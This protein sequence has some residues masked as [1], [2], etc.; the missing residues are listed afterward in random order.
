M[1][2]GC[3][4]S[5]ALHRRRSPGV[6]VMEMVTQ[7]ETEIVQGRIGNGRGGFIYR[8]F[9]SEA[10]SINVVYYGRP[11]DCSAPYS[12][13]SLLWSLC[14]VSLKASLDPETR[15]C[16]FVGTLHEVTVGKQCTYHVRTIERQ[17][18]LSKTTGNPLKNWL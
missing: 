12:V 7:M 9:P 3:V 4:G 10:Y 8:F 17:E 16:A 2:G 13:L 15:A 18:L 6:K 14:I 1:N 11:D 5:V